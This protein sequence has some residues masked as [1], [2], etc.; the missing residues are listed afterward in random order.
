[1]A[2]MTF[3]EAYQEDLADAFFDDEEFASSHIIDGKECT[4][5]LIDVK[6][7]GARKYYERSRSTFNP[8]ETAI[9]KVSY[10]LYVREA[11][12][13]RKKITTNAVIELDGKKYF[14]LNV[15][16][17]AGIYTLAIGIHAV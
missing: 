13:E 10:I 12:I 6:N 7:E 16:L 11:D 17:S 8:K 14:V 2:N 9:N 3:K 4:V 1:M 5:I 15:G